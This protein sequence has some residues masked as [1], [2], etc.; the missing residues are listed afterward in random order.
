MARSERIEAAAGDR[1][2]VIDRSV[3]RNH[4]S[5]P[6]KQKPDG[7]SDKVDVRNYA[8]TSS[9]D[10]SPAVD[11]ALVLITLLPVPARPVMRD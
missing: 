10:R 7:W 8:T 3:Y 9:I 4:Q 6:K 1:P 11:P 2:P 5:H